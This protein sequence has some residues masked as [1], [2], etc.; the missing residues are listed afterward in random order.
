VKKSLERQ[1]DW[2]QRW[3]FRRCT[4]QKFD[5]RASDIVKQAGEIARTDVARRLAGPLCVLKVGMCFFWGADPGGQRWG[6]REPAAPYQVNSKTLRE[7]RSVKAQNKSNE[8]KS[9]D[10]SASRS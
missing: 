8:S 1:V 7:K 6:W 5:E 9:F 4:E 10:F 3:K 2:N